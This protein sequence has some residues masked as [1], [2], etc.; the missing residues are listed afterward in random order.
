VVSRPLDV[1]IVARAS[2]RAFSDLDL[3]LGHLRWL[4]SRP[5]EGGRLVVVDEHAGDLT[6]DGSNART[7]AHEY[8]GGAVWYHGDAVFYSEFT[9]GRIRRVGHGPITPVAG[10]HRYADGSVSADGSTVFC[11]RERHEEGE[12]LNELVSFP[13]D[14]SA[15]PTV[16]ASGRDFYMAP[17][18]APDG[19]L[20]WLEWDHPRMPWDGTELV[21]DGTL[22]A[23]GP[24][25]SVI[26][27]Q[28]S[29][30]GKLHW[31]SDRTGWWNLYRDG[32]PLTA[33][34]GAEI[35][36]PAWVFGMQRY[37]FLDD[38]R[39]V[40]V[41]T[42]NASDELHVLDPTSGALRR[43]AERWTAIGLGG[44]ATAGTRVA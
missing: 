44:I 22:V 26:D 6:P 41:V 33:L 12:V 10:D 15:E 43:F 34:E 2:G 23:G 18:V 21:V 17:R 25:E 32:E 20:A 35:G 27:P 28:W 38:G 16:V 37:A 11:V 19:R 3:S 29:P 1:R 5:E 24:E 7:R 36:F 13:A 9:D 42:R 8:G 30:D 4:E 39:I 14:G 40:C 31:L